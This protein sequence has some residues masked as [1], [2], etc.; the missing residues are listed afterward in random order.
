MLY[1]RTPWAA[2]FIRRVGLAD[3]NEALLQGAFLF[4]GLI[5]Y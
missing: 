3:F 5:R 4:H 2:G 1:A